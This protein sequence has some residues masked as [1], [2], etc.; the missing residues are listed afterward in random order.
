VRLREKFKRWLFKEELQE[1]EIAMNKNEEAAKNLHSAENIY[2][3][4]YWLVDDCHKLINS[5]TN[6]GVDICPYDRSWAVVCIKGHPEY[7]EFME[8]SNNDT[9][10]IIDFLKH[11]KYSNRVI[12]SPNNI[13][14]NQFY[15]GNK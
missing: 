15:K 14:M 1:F 11:F 10:E 6:V 5:M 13:I 3:K 4:S 12:D 9:R 7:V 8:L 2:L